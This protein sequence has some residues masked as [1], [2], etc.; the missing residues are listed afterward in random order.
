MFVYAQNV[1]DTIVIESFNYTQTYGVNQWSPGIRDTIIDFSI[2]PNQPIEKVLMLYNMRCKNNLVSN[3]SNRDQG[4]GEWDASCNIYLHDSTRTDSVTYTHPNYL[5]SNFS[6]TTFAYTSQEIY[7]L[8]KY[9][10]NITTLNTI[11]SENSYNIL[12]GNI[13]SNT[14]LGGSNK[15][16]KS[17]Y[18]YTAGELSAAGFSA[19]E[20]DGIMLNAINSGNINFLELN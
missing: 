18:L 3:S 20:I 17:Q 16:G 15:S 6:G 2:L 19:G 5:I 1:G 13:N 9:E 8:Y 10:E 7:D 11:I 4:C 14:T 12:N